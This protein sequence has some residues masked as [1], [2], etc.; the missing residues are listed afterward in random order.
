MNEQIQFLGNLFT[1][2][3]RTEMPKTPAD[4]GLDYD[5]VTFATADGVNLKAWYIPAE[6]SNK[7]ILM[8]HPMM[9][10]RYGYVPPEAMMNLLPLPV[11][12]LNT[13]KQLNKAGYSVLF[14]DF[15]NHGKS[16]DGNNGVCGIGHFEY[17]D[18]IAM[19]Q[20]V[21]KHEKLSGMKKAFLSECMGANA[22]I[23]A[24]IEKPELFEDIKALISV[25][26]FS[27]DIGLS[28]VIRLQFPDADEAELMAAVDKYMIENKGLSLYDASPKKYVKDLKVPVMYVKLKNEMLTRPEDTQELYDNTTSEK[29]LLWLDEEQPR[30]Y[31]YNYFGLH[32][33]KMLEF[34]NK[35]IN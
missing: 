20:Y 33:E 3:L 7:L 29:E 17:L 5:D 25:Q 31:A 9:C 34:F 32:P 2:P 19:K 4:Y 21:D 13:V 1:T 15:R 26:A 30:F 11:E 8:A 24:M 18:V 27:S 22:T 16:D 14:M 28:Q 12:F 6:G 35:Y 10:T 23:K